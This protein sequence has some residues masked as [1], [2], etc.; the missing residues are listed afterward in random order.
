MILNRAPFYFNVVFPNTFVTNVNFT[1]VVGTGSTT[2]I[3]PTKTYTF[4]R[5]EYL[6]RY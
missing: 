6:V 1:L 4:N 5:N 2:T 3:V